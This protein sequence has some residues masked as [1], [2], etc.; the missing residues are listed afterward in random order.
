VTDP[1]GVPNALAAAT[2]PYLLQHADNP[3]DWQEWGP[4]AFEQA[5]ARDVPV[6]VSV[7][8]AA[9]HWCHVMAHESFE[10]EGVAEFMNAHFV[11]VKVDREE[12]PDVD[13]V[14]MAATQAMTGAGGWPMTVF[15]TPT[16]EPFF[17]GTYFPPRRMHQMASFSEVLAGVAAAWTARRDEVVASAD[18]IRQ[19][20][21]DR[22]GGGAAP[23]ARY[24]E[25]VDRAL[26]TLAST[27]DAADGGFGGAPKF[28]P[29]MVLEWLLRHH[30]RTGDR[31]ALEMAEQTLDPM[32]R[33]GMYDQLGGGFARY[34]VDATWTVPHFEKMLYDNALLLRV[35]AHAWRSTAAPLARRVALE[36]AR[37][38]LED[39]RLPEGGF[40]SSLDADTEGREGAFYVWTPAQLRE[41]L[42]DDDGRWAADLLRVTDQGT[43]EHGTSVLQRRGEPD[44]TDRFDRV[45]AQ[46]LAARARRPAPGLDDKVVTGWNGLA[47]SALAEAGE[48]FDRPD[49]V[50]AA[51]GAASALVGTHLRRHDD[52]STRLVRS[53]R[54]G[55]PSLAAGVLEDYA[56]L[57]DGLLALFAVTGDAQWFT[58]AGGLL[59][60]VL[61]HFAAAD[62]GFH[63]TA[64]D[65]TD[66]VVALLG[67]PK[68]PADGPTPS[69]QSALAG[70]LLTYAAL[71]GS[72]RHRE[73]A[74]DALAGALAVATRWP[75]AAGAGL[76]VLEAM[77]DGPREVAIIG[78]RDDPRTT[79]LRSLAMRSVA[80]GLVLAVG[81][82]GDDRDGPAL[83]HD[84]P[85][86]DGAP[87]AYVCRG[88]VCSRP[89][90]D[91]DELA[92]QLA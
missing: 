38:M 56:N 89:T 65:E 80:P 52:G 88:F 78:A 31:R 35:Y 39:L 19:A 83:L 91:P 85:L 41:V 22:S 10:D 8:Y 47:I 54:G 58:V 9:C 59:D 84:R 29:S 6:L 73:A 66:P 14:Y 70:A 32:A 60:T 40:A 2:S 1:E 68:D 15:T 44:D 7:G 27:F 17:C 26:V 25:V 28:P 63:D 57:A 82:P 12:R 21:A 34:S 79:A 4:A 90:T 30:A 37:W 33:G 74:E 43:F 50:E 51:V 69:G 16:G 81:E 64:D 76:A 62:G 77:L 48:L 13:A 5:A 42:G 86:V 67:R 24:G 92:R 53:S 72:A 49:L 46:L 23:A 3:V 11:C 61:D 71:T 75:R 36:T 45:R 87:T 18:A 20:L 55:V